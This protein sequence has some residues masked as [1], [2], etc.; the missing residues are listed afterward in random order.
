MTARDPN[1]HAVRRFAL[2]RTIVVATDLT[3]QEMLVPY[4]VSEA[5]RT[6]A[7]VVLVHA[8]P[9]TPDAS[10]LLV[11]PG[12]GDVFLDA[13]E[14][15]ETMQ[16]RIQRH[17]ISCSIKLSHKQPTEAVEAAI[18]EMHADRLIAGSRGRRNVQEFLLGSTARALMGVI[19]VPMLFVGPN[20]RATIDHS[21][22]SILCVI[23]LQGDFEELAR[24]ALSVAEVHD[25]RI[26]LLHVLEAKRDEDM[27]PARTEEWT[28]TALRALIENYGRRK[29]H[30]V[31]S[32]ER[33]DFLTEALNAARVSAADLLITGTREPVHRSP[34]RDGRA[35]QL[36]AAAPMPVLCYRVNHAS[37]FEQAARATESATA[38]R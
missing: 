12:S 2:P 10:S 6:G 1:H 16:K 34:L 4:V 14:A 25:A 29:D 35:Y 11:S 24:F 38:H 22:R 17:G 30:A 36:V 26:V 9:F 13:L 3:D 7:L 28:R 31:V 27:N 8:T 19:Q 18:A 15:L 21:I 5:R 37:A 23:S 32:V 20:C 33:G